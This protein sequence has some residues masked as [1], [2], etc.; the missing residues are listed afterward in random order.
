[1]ASTTRFI[2]KDDFA[3]YKIISTYIANADIDPYILQAQE[4]RIQPIL[5]QTIYENLQTSVAASS[6]TAADLALIA[7]LTPF[8][9]YKSFSVYLIY[10]NIKATQV[11][12][13]KLDTQHSTLATDE[14]MEQIKRETD[15]MG[16]IYEKELRNF[17]ENNKDTYS[18][19]SCEATTQ[20]FG[21]N[22]TYVT[23]TQTTRR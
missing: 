20:R 4:G 15:N 11:G 10:V 1:M 22:L 5:T 12:F 8:L 2:N 9:V 23:K 19:E 7:A 14:E 3:P 18:W 13:V 17:L 16:I 21:P 6:E